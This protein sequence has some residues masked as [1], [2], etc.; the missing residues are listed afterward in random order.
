MAKK[1][2]LL[3]P[4]HEADFKSHLDIFEGRIPYLY[5]DSGGL[6]TVGCGCAVPSASISESLN[7][8][9][10]MASI[11]LAASEWQAVKNSTP[12]LAAQSYAHL[13][14]LRLSDIEIDRL[15]DKRIDS[16]ESDLI[17]AVTGVSRLPQPAIQC[18]IDMCFNIGASKL[19]RDFFGPTSKFGPALYAGD[20]ATAAA[21]SA[22]RGIQPARN[23]YARGLLLFCAS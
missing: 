17:M 6:P 1:L 12:G 16:T 13:T 19:H 20:W 9:G 21:E 7:W 23:D 2:K 10:G 11:A 18:L 22:R 14:M 4:E 5:S 3:D 8:D 15:R